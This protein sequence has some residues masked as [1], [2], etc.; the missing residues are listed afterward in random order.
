MSFVKLG[1][2][3]ALSG[4]GGRGIVEAE[5]QARMA[6][7]K[8]LAGQVTGMAYRGLV[9]ASEKGEAGTGQASGSN[10]YAH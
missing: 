10:L 5:R 9:A 2:T 8:D 6:P 7:D 3:Q 1:G 4:A